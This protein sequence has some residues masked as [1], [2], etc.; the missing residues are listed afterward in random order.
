MAEF[1]RDAW[2]RANAPE[3]DAERALKL[4]DIIQD[5][6]IDCGVGVTDDDPVDVC[7]DFREDGHIVGCASIYEGILSYYVRDVLSTD[8]ATDEQLIDAI[9][10][11]IALT[12]DEDDVILCTHCGESLHDEEND[13]FRKDTMNHKCLPMVRKQ[14]KELQ[15]CLDVVLKQYIYPIESGNG[16]LQLIAHARRDIEFYQNNVKKLET[17]YEWEG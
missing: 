9:K 16:S 15:T 11:R 10:K 1:D 4:R 6:G 13:V 8:N 3:A 17:D 12:E 14:L 2:V 7:L 5:L